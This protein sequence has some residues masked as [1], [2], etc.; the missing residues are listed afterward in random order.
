[1]ND[2]TKKGS[3]DNFYLNLM[4]NNVSMGNM[5]DKVN[6]A[7]DDNTA[8]STTAADA[9]ADGDGHDLGIAGGTHIQV[10]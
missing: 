4:H 8:D 5:V 3:L 10:I 6:P 9:N 1:M 7:S 2:P